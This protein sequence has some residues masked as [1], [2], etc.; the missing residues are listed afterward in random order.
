VFAHPVAPFFTI[1]PMPLQTEDPFLASP[2]LPHEQLRITVTARRIAYLKLGYEPIPVLSGRKRPA[3]SRWQDVRITIPPD[4]DVITPWA[5]TYPGALSTGIRTRYTPGFDIDIRDQDV[6]DQV[7]QVLLNMIPQQ[8]TVLK[9]VGLP[10]KRLIPFRCVTSFKKISATFKAPDDVVHKVEVLCDGQQF[11]A[12]GIHE[13]TQQPYRWAGNVSLLNVA[14]EHLPLV[15]EAL[16]RRFVGE[17]GEIMRR[18]GWIEVGAKSNGMNNGKSN[19]KAGAETKATETRGSSIYGR[20]AL[21]AECDK[22]AA[23]PKDSGRNNAL[24]S[25]AFSLFQLVAGGEL[26]EEKD[27]VPEGL[28]AAAEACG[29]VAED[30]AASVRAT[31]ESGARAGLQQPRR[32]PV[33]GDDQDNAQGDNQDDELRTTA[34]AVLEM[35]GITWLW[36]GRLALGKIGLI[37]GLPDYG[38]GQIAAFIVAAVTAAIELP[39]GEGNA[40]HGNVIWF[41]AEDDARDTVLP[42]LVAAGADPKLVHFVNGARIAGEDKS[43]NLVTDLPLLRKKIEQIGNVVLVIIDPMSAYLGVGRVDGRSATDVRGVLTPIK[44]LAEVLHVAVIGIAHFNKKD[45]IKSALLRVSDSIAYVAAARHVYA[46]LDDPE[47]SNAK[48]FVKAK[49][50]L[51]PDKKALRYGFGVK[52]VGHDP[53]LGVDIDAPFIVWHPQHVELTANEAMQAV[54]GQ[55][56]FAKREARDFLLERLAAGPAKSEE[57]IEEARQ[58][59]IA[60]RTLYRAKKELQIRSRKKMGE[61]RGEWTW[62]LPTKTKIATGAAQ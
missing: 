46:V 20:T 44:D 62:E 37:A 14:H 32:A 28:F 10:P 54:T 27:Q 53:K 56:G 21:R 3:I 19:G 33:H 16:G 15:D 35:R 59:G 57:V 2:P 26:D 52:T 30:G 11:V 6:A 23:M 58:N 43:F 7:E 61:T 47:D 48:L 25:A 31:V 38:K 18:A 51:A 8:G 24:N 45:D 1:S 50:N 55:S 17:A 41:N 60:E 36:P 49:N 29:L 5:K 9:R 22:L 4:E 12:E 39:C 42:R 13:T 34:A 40:P